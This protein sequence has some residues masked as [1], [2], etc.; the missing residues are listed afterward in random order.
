VGKVAGLNTVWELKWI[1]EV[2]THDRLQGSTLWFK[3]L[4]KF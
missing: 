1:D 4:S 2:Q 3:V